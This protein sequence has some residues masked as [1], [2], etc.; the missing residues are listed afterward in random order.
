M[1]ESL[2]LV[3]RRMGSCVY[4]HFSTPT[5]GILDGKILLYLFHWCI[6]CAKKVMVK[7]LL[8]VIQLLP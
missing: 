1:K 5:Y 2:E 3:N 8:N 7:L 4:Y 6:L